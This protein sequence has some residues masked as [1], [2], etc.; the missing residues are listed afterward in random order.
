[1]SKNILLESFYKL[2]NKCYTPSSYLRRD[3]FPLSMWLWKGLLNT[4]LRLKQRPP[5]Q[6]P[7]IAWNA[8][9]EIQKMHKSKFLCP[10]WMQDLGKWFGAWDATHLVHDTSLDLRPFATTM[11]VDMGKMW[12]FTLHT[13]YY[14]CCT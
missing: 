14:T 2:R 12:R 9:K 3:H 11:Y 4:W 8:S 5:H 1:M 10:G 7:R 13:S 6:L